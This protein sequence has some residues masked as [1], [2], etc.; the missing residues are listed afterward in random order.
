MKCHCIEGRGEETSGILLF[1]AVLP[2]RRDSSVSGV[3]KSE[4][5]YIGGLRNLETIAAVLQRL[6]W[7]VRE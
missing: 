4:G 6:V 5:P 7:G 1:A 3:Y 2:E